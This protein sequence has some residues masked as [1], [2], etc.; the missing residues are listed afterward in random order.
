MPAGAA[1]KMHQGFADAAQGAGEAAVGIILRGGLDR[2]INQDGTAHDGV[3]VHESPVAAIQTAVTII[4]EH[5]I[6]IRGNDEFA[7]L[8]VIENPIGPFAA[9]RDFDEVAIGRGKIITKGIF[10][11]G[12]VDDVRLIEPRAINVDIAVD[13]ANA[14]AGQTDDAFDVVR[15]IFERKF[16]DDD[17]AAADG[18]VRQKFFIPGAATAEDK[19]VHEY[20]IA[21][22][23]GGFHGWRRNFEGLHHESGAEEREEHGDEEQFGEF[24]EGAAPAEHVR[25]LDGRGDGGFGSFD[26]PRSGCFDFHEFLF[27]RLVQ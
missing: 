3:A 5:E 22:Q 23:Q 11:S 13:D 1:G 21:D 19:F 6:M 25:M 2:P 9:R 8:D 7:I 10:V 12:I 17:I 18:A 4:A 20:M 26:G 24:S 14:V 15:V 16:E 27:V